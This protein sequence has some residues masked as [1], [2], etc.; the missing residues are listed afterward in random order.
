MLFARFDASSGRLDSSF[1]DGGVTLIDFGRGDRASW[2]YGHSIVETDDGKLVGF[3]TAI[4]YLNGGGVSSE[5]PRLVAA[6]VGLS[7]GEHSGTIGFRSTFTDAFEGQARLV[8]AIRRMGGTFGSLS[9]DYVT[10]PA[11]ATAGADFTAVS[12][13]L[14]WADGEASAK[15][16]EVALIADN[17]VEG[18]EYFRLRLTGAGDAIAA[19][20]MLVRLTDSVVSGPAVQGPVV[21]GPAVQGPAVQGPAVGGGG[22]ALGIETL[23]LLAALLARNH[24][25]GR[26]LIRVRRTVSVSARCRWAAGDDGATD[27]PER[28]RFSARDRLRAL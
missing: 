3:G 5:R 25:Y 4:D 11:T 14:T 1:G 8:V 15:T 10:E 13:T 7:A 28:T 9:I 24:G 16:F 17:V 6:R 22:G 19:S 18:A 27:F 21:Q 2:A 12:G 26:S 20:E 23:L